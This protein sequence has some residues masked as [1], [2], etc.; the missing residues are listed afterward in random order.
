MRPNPSISALR[1]GTVE[2]RPNPKAVTRGTVT[3]DVVTPPE[4]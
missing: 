1:P 2:A 3:V 4:S